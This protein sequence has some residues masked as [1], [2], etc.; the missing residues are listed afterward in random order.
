MNLF[1]YFNSDQTIEFPYFCVFID[2]KLILKI[3]T[4]NYFILFNIR[5]IYNMSKAL[6]RGKFIVL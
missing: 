2:K 5:Y 4:N 3:W 6:P 1:I